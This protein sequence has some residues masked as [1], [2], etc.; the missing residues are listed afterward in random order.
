MALRFRKRIKLFKGVYLNVSNSGMSATI[1]ARGASVNIGKRGAYLNIGIPHTGLYERVKLDG[2][3]NANDKEE[4]F[5]DKENQTE[6]GTGIEEAVDQ[7]QVEFMLGLA[8]S[9]C[10]NEEKGC[11]LHKEWFKVKALRIALFVIIYIVPVIVYLGI[12]FCL[13]GKSFYFLIA[14]PLLYFVI[15]F[16]GAK[17]LFRSLKEKEKEK[18]EHYFIFANGRDL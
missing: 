5:T 13:K 6:R 11:A 7:R 12:M 18:E 15:M 4:Y 1:G 9:I 14:P 10:I 8:N 2:F 17:K 16:L 3:F